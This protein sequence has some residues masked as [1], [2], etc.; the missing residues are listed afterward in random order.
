MTVIAWFCFAAVAWFLTSSFTWV[1]S[2]AATVIKSF[3]YLLVVAALA[4]AIR[5]SI[6]YIYPLLLQQLDTDN[7]REKLH[8][9]VQPI[10]EAAK[11]VLEATA[12]WILFTFNNNNNNSTSSD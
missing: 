5:E 3:A 6:L 7:L 2:K 9:V 12:N 10:V 8:S 11:P 4:V 1:V